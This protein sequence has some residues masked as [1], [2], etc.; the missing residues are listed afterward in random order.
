MSAGD[1]LE[2]HSDRP[3]TVDHVSYTSQATGPI[4]CGSQKRFSAYALGEQLRWNESVAILDSE[5]LA[6]T[7]AV[8]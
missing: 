7:G 8:S 5:G 3:N 4:E 6:Q 1:V 2:D